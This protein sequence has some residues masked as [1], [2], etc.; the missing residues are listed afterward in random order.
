MNA[1]SFETWLEHHLL[2]TLAEGDIV[3]LDNLKAHKGSRVAA[4]LAKKTA[5][6]DTC[7]PTARTSIPSRWRSPS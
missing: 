3:V 7:R 2:P 1:E 4:I 5:R 6:S